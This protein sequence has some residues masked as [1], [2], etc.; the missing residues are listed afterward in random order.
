MND[1]SF[2]SRAYRGADLAQEFRP[3]PHGKGVAPG[4][5]GDRNAPLDELH[6][7]P[8]R[9]IRLDP[10]VVQGDD[11]RMPECGQDLLFFREMGTA[12][13]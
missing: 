12:R 1:E 8:W 5:L 11:P 13:G 7:E 9:P 4:K 10:R 6:R 3:A 2:V